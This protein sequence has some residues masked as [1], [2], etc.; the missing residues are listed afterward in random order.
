MQY[1]ISIYFDERTNKAFRGYIEKVACRSGNTYMTEH[2]VPAH[3]TVTA[4]EA[5][6]EDALIAAVE[7]CVTK[8]QCGTLQ[9]VSVGALP[10]GVLYIAPVLNEYLYRMSE[11]LCN[12]IKALE[13]VR[14]SRYYQPFQWLPH[15]TIAKK[16]TNQEMMKGFDVLQSE[17]VCREGKV[18]RIGVAAKNPYKEIREWSLCRDSVRQ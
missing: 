9:W 8:L 5:E 10:N 15:T 18:V 4:F 11:V 14:M 1:L 17:F 7:R 12:E 6:D 2:Q 16:L 3:I 13:G